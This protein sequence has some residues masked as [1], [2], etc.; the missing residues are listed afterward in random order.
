VPPSSCRLRIFSRQ[1]LKSHYLEFVYSG[2]SVPLRGYTVRRARFSFEQLDVARLPE[3][4]WDRCDVTHTMQITKCENRCRSCAKFLLHAQWN[5]RLASGFNEL[6]FLA[7]WVICCYT[8]AICFSRDITG[9]LKFGVI[10]RTA[11]W[12]VLG[13]DKF[14]Q[15]WF[16]FIIVDRISRLNCTIV[17]SLPKKCVWLLRN[18]WCG[19]WHRLAKRCVRVQ[20]EQQ[21][22]YPSFHYVFALTTELAIGNT[23]EGK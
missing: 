11:A 6:H 21:C 13:S 23:R 10:T 18:F 20:S 3:V 9:C 19:R 14:K 15:S 22:K 8:T 4:L 16:I 12:S 5:L 7:K 1:N 17:T 2:Q